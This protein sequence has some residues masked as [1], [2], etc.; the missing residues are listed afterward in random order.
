MFRFLPFTLIFFSF[1]TVKLNA[2][3]ECGADLIR[4]RQLSDPTYLQQMRDFEN[5]LQQPGATGN[6]QALTLN[7]STTYTIPVV[8]H[9][10]HTGGAV[11]TIYNPSDATIQA[12]MTYMNNVYANSNNAGVNIQ[13][14]FALAQRTPDCSSTTG[15]VR[16]NGSSVTNYAL[17]GMNLANTTGADELTIKNL[18]RWDPTSYLNVW[19][20]N[21][22]DN[23]DGTSGA[24][25]AGF[26]Y[27]P[28]VTGT[29]DGIVMLATQVGNGFETLP[30]E[31]GHYLGLYHTFQGDGSGA[32]CP[33]DATCGISG[34]CCADTPPHRRSNNTCPTA[35]TT[36]S[37]A[38]SNNVVRNYMD[39]SS[40]QDR[41]TADQKSRMRLTMGT[42]RP[43]LVSSQ[44]TTA[45]SGSAPTAACAPG[46]TNAS[47]NLNMGPLLVSMGNVEVASG[48][49]GQEG[50][51]ADYSCNQ[52]VL[53][54]PG[55]TYGISVSTATNPQKV[56]V[57][58]DYN[59]NGTLNDAGELVY[60]SNATGVP[61]THTGNITIP[62]SPAFLNTKLRMRVWADFS[63]ATNN[64]PCGNLQY[65]Q[66]E[67]YGLFIQSSAPTIST[68]TV[69]GSPFCAGE[70]ISIPYTVTGIFNAGNTFTAQ[71]SSS[72]GSFAS[73]VNIGTLSSTNSGSISAQIPAGSTAG[74]AYRIR[75]VGSSP[76][77]TGSNNG[78]NLEIATIPAAAISGNASQNVC[79]GESIT[80]SA[81]TGTGLSYR[82]FRNNNLISGA[83]SSTHS[84]GTAG[85][86]TVEVSNAAGCADTSAAV[87]V[88]VIASPGASTSPAG[89]QSICSGQTL[90]LN[91]NT[92]TGL[93]Y[94]WQ[95]NG[96]NAANGTSS[97]FSTGQAGSYR[98]IVSGSNGC[99]D[100]SAT[101]VVTVNAAPVASITPAGPLSRC[102]GRRLNLSAS[103]GAGYQY[104]W[105]LNGN[106]IS[107][108]TASVYAADTGGTFRVIA[109]VGSC[110]DTSADVVISTISSPGAS[111][112]PAS[113][114]F[115]TGTTVT[116]RGNTGTGFSYAWLRNNNLVPGANQ[117]SL[118]ISSNTSVRVI[119]SAPN[120]CTDTSAAGS[121][122]FSLP[123]TAATIPAGV[124]SSCQGSS[125]TYA[126]SPTG[127]GLS[128]LWMRNG[129]P[130]SG[131]TSSSYQPTQSGN[132]SVI[133][134]L[135]ICSDSSQPSIFTLNSTY[136]QNLN[137]QACDNNP[138]RLPDGSNSSATGSVQVVLQTVQ[139]CDSIFDVNIIR[140]TT[141]IITLSPSVQFDLCP[142]DSLD[143]TASGASTYLWNTGNTTA[144]QTATSGGWLV[145]SGSTGACTARDSVFV[146]LLAGLN[147][148]AINGADT[149][150]VGDTLTY[151]LS[152]NTG[153]NLQWFISGGRIIGNASGSSVQVVWNT[154]GTGSIRADGQ[155]GICSESVQLPVRIFP[156][157]GIF[158]SMS[159]NWLIYPN[160][161]SS[162]VVIR[163][164]SAKGFEWKFSDP[165][166]KNLGEGFCE[167]AEH[168]INM[169]AL[170][171]GLYFIR[172]TD[173][174]QS[175]NIPI[176]LLK[177]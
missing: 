169:Q 155:S 1:W 102:S 69:S 79:S 127:A 62:A 177:P 93:S 112:T 17:R 85:S 8:F 146:N 132:Y 170:P 73:P 135:G 115:C 125:F 137:L 95:R 58:I 11:G 74:T 176:V 77:T 87:V 158:E 24:F 51:L 33:S 49:G 166:G 66:A 70:N 30:H 78:T 108:A 144:V 107:G 65:G 97:A 35:A 52:T 39:Y 175:R 167:T 55:Q 18:S 128:Y 88:T 14:Q 99:L 2:Q 44:G 136:R 133:V 47:N 165:E 3:K 126:A 94:Q 140:N 163:S 154:I 36:C 98:V 64:G 151:S 124:Q 89:N 109:S 67:D 122:T 103:T 120:G 76:A 29:L 96:S 139:G 118:R 26:A 160:P 143:V 113:G 81:N 34:D 161:T 90:S 83:T 54:N 46:L 104:L 68:G 16:I 159:S 63:T 92:G 57:Y 13:L 59:N 162:V 141:P 91:A 27:I 157:S 142:G 147:L 22:I 172:L 111:F 134:S 110:S 138:V 20:V 10:I 100:T 153:A 40:C 150:N 37:G 32:T 131:A 21:K 148:G 130:I 28:P 9:V 86:Y 121:F 43:G 42:Y 82:W 5:R 38:P 149:V 61:Q 75:V 168:Q 48:S 156:V 117:D 105:Q 80:L 12:M 7:P 19:V 71:L 123:P 41:F 23:S 6:A 45:P 60:S 84:T 25:T 116:L 152:G 72:S 50:P 173:H 164:E 174:H 106:T 15:I 56:R 31:A 145:V 171:S 53:V 101:V 4:M 114:A 119:V 129:A